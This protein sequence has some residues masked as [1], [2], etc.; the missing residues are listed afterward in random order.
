MSKPEIR[1]A[2][3]AD[4]GKLAQIAR[5]TFIQTFGH[6]YPPTDL[7]AFLATAYAAE[8]MRADLAD[9]ARAAWL[10]EAGDEA[11]GYAQVG[12][13][14]LPHPD[15]TAASGEVKRLYLL[16]DW[17]SGGL[18]RR[19][20]EMTL[21]WLEREGRRDLFIGVWS[22]NHGAQRFYRRF[23]FDHVGEYG[24]PVGTVVDREFIYRRRSR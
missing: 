11:V 22:G 3:L 1:R 4:A 14:E 23:G 10:V 19:L 12:P 15:V 18:G 9:P 13:C 2:G 21:D 17:Q 16:R 20:F 6:L 7:A 8:R 24:F 5:Q